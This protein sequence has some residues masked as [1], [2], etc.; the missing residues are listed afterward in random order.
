MKVYWK[1]AASGDF[2]TSADWTP[3]VP[4]GAG[5]QAMLTATGASYTVSVSSNQTVL[6]I[7]TSAYADLDIQNNVTFTAEDGTG[8]GANN[9]IIHAEPGS[10]FEVAGTINNN[11]T[12]YLGNSSQ[13][14]SG[15]PYTLM[16]LLGDTTLNGGALTIFRNGEVTGG[17]TLTNT[18]TSEISGAGEIDVA[19][20]NKKTV[21]GNTTLTPVIDGTS[22]A[23]ALTLNGVVTNTGELRSEG[24]A[25]L[26]I[27]N[28][29]FNTGGLI[30][31]YSVLQIIDGADIVG[32]TLQNHKSIFEVVDGGLDGSGTHPI[33]LD[34][35]IDVGP[36]GTLLTQGV[37]KN[38]PTGN[39]NFELDNGASLLLGFSNAT[40]MDTTL[41]TTTIGGGRI[42]LYQATIDL[43][44]LTHAGSTPLK[45]N[46]VNDVISGSGTIG[47]SATPGSFVL[48]NETKG[49]VAAD[50]GTLSIYSNVTN[51]G[52]LE[53]FSGTLSLVGNVVTNTGSLQAASGE[54][55][56]LEST[57][58]RGGTLTGAGTFN[59]ADAVLDGSASALTNAGTIDMAIQYSNEARTL[60][61]KGTINNTGTIELGPSNTSGGSG[62]LPPLP[63]GSDLVI[64]PSGASNTVTLKGSGYIQL[65]AYGYGNDYIIGDA[66]SP[67]GVATTLYNL[68]NILGSGRIGDGGLTLRN[69][70]RIISTG[71]LVIDTGARTVTNTGTMQSADGSLYIDSPLNNTGGKLD[72]VGVSELDAIMGATGGTAMLEHSGII[73][74]GGP[75]TTA[76]QFEDDSVDRRQLVLDDSVHFKGVISGFDS[77]KS[78]LTD[79]IDL[80]DIDSATA[81]KV[82][83]TGGVL[84]IKDGQGHTTQ[85]H[86]SGSYTLANFNIASDG[87]G[88]TLLT[89]PPA[90]TKPQSP[91]AGVELLANYIASAFAPAAANVSP[92]TAGNETAQQLLNIAAP[93][94]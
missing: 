83:Y 59:A 86:F 6:T 13:S 74:F 44:P 89:D 39:F 19:V 72:A 56:N 5:D 79:S 37:F 18:G 82:S 47:N 68:S 60:T 2:S 80:L 24:T 69:G 77:N 1:T 52:V 9:G 17:G 45:L 7:D 85:L 81:Q 29:V 14:G 87:H 91:V 25:G 16:V 36:G 35:T 63:V 15:T 8:P 90:P 43:N 54:V 11:G 27:A 67:G 46:N 40:A 62:G 73:E 57:T 31:S 10:T 41:G 84:T 49:T 51:A 28:T 93:H 48:N 76:V 34:G 65:D 75:T 55:F 38:L 71:P 92:L 50:N 23:Q 70:G 30:D 3:S 58:I 53:A 12:I 94:A 78:N 26:T 64:G 4:P 88:G 33:S 22:A 21:T 61:L 32:G 20:N 42:D 66:D